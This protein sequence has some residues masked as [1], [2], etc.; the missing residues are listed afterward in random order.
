MPETA[1][2]VLRFRERRSVLGSARGEADAAVAHHHTGDT[3]PAARCG[4]R[5]PRQLGIE[6]GVDVD[7]AGRHQAPVGIDLTTRRHLD[8][9][10]VEVDD[11]ADPVTGDAHVGPPGWRARSVDDGAA[12]NDD[13]VLHA[14]S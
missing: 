9:P 3:V 7:E 4:Q 10:V 5:I 1:T 11:L 6:M 8:A 13:V 12:A 14:A 2:S